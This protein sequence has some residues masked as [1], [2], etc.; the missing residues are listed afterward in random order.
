MIIRIKK[1][2]LAIVSVLVILTIALTF[3]IS[4]PLIY[5]ATINTTSG[6]FGVWIVIS[7]Q[8]PTNITLSNVTGFAVDPISGTDAVIIIT[9]NASDPDGVENING[10]DGGR[11]FVNLT[12]GTEG[13]QFRTSSTCTNYTDAAAGHVVFNCTI[14]MRYYDNQSSDWV[15][16]ITVIDANGA[17]ARNSSS[18]DNSPNTFTYNSLSAFSMTANFPGEAANLNFTSLNIGDTDKPGKAP[19]LLNNTG[20]DDF[21]QI[22]ITAAALVS[23]GNSIAVTSFAINITNGTA[24]KGQPLSLTS[25]TI[26]APGSGL[27][28]A[29]LKHGPG[30]SG[31]TVPY[32]GITDTLGNLSLYFWIDVPTGLATGTYNNTWNITVIN[33]P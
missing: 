17:I 5:A 30:I 21:D 7:N 19:I 14:I 22:N 31:D 15:I 6:G 13:A 2:S 27:P 24:G 26:R 33:L 20:N 23:G 3:A 18:G 4:L 32:V 8:V 12:L 9:F 28:N 16:N 1:R 10:T 29:S 11:V 25:L